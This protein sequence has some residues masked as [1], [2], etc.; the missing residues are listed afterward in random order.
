M[1]E[2]QH[3]S[4]NWPTTNLNLQDLNK[5]IHFVGPVNEGRQ[6]KID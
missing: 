6:R 5:M 2:N 1:I 3:A 4:Q